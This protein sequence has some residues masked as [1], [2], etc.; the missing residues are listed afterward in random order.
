MPESILVAH[1]TLLTF[2]DPCRVLPDH[3]LLVEGDRIQRMAPMEVFKDFKG[4]RL[5]AQGKVVIPGLINAHMH[6]YSTFARGLGGLAPSSD[7]QAILRNLWWRLDRALDLEAVELSALSA[8]FNAIRRGTTTLIDH[9]ASPC[10]VRGSLDALAGAVKASGLRA[11]L[12]YEVSNRDGEA[13]AMAGLEENATF[14]SRCILAQ[15]SHLRA[16]VGLHASFTLGREILGRAAELGASQ[17]VGFHIHV[18]ED[19]SDQVDC[20]SRYG[21]R[22]VERLQGAG[23]LGPRTLAAHGVHLGPKERRIL[24]DTRTWLA[25]NPQSNLNNAVGIADLPALVKDGVRVVLG[26]DAMTV[27]MLEE[28]RVG[29]WAQHWGQR[30]PSAGFQE[31]VHTLM[32]ENPRLAS[33]LWEDRVG[34]LEEGALADLIVVDYDPPTPL[35]VDNAAGHVVFGLSQAPVHSTMCG[36]RI[37]MEG[38]RLCLDLDEG[39]VMARCRESSQKVWARL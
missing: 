37:L 2:G 7:F 13:A 4:R 16:L 8:L 6:F 33:Q 26:T 9:H 12:C 32:V 3:G 25:H 30:D 27:S 10:A 5:E 29:L 14:L 11:C 19:A 38:F 20:M 23:I 21:L 17:G 1:G 24:A 18:A 31:V 28:L 35:N 22:V 39:E 36:G 15:D 34:V